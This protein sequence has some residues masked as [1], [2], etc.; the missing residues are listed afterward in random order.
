MP[1]DSFFHYIFTVELWKLCFSLNREVT[2]NLTLRCDQ[3]NKLAGK[4]NSESIENNHGAKCQDNLLCKFVWKVYFNRRSQSVDT[5]DSHEYLHILPSTLKRIFNR[6][7]FHSKRDSLESRNVHE[8]RQGGWASR[9][10]RFLERSCRPSVI[11]ALRRRWHEYTPS[12]R[13]PLLRGLHTH[14]LLFQPLSQ[15][16]K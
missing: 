11:A 4:T 5:I 3:W 9:G 10:S 13:N 7:N 1:R 2:V 15:P 8:N 16:R 12:T 14:A 6:S